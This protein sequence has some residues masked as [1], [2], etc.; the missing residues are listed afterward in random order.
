MNLD[1]PTDKLS[2]I[3]F[4]MSSMYSLM[5]IREHNICEVS[6]HGKTYNIDQ[7][8]LIVLTTRLPAESMEL[9]KVTLGSSKV[10]GKGVFATQRIHNDELITFYPADIVEYIPNGDRG[11]NNHL[12]IPWGS[13]HFIE[14]FGEEAVKSTTHRNGD[15]AFEINDLYTIIGH[16]EFDTDLNYLGH[17]INDGAKCGPTEQSKNIYLRVSQLKQNCKFKIVGKGLHV[18]IIATRDIEKDEEI[19]I[20]YGISYWEFYHK[21]HQN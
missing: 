17:F 12:T 13:D 21:R 8:K 18:A 15:Y 3:E 19:Y 14:K 16:P 4:L 1:K 7:G 11:H 20:P 10:H 2:K 6:V 5:K 9:N